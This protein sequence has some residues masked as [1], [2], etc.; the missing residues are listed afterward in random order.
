MAGNFDT[1]VSSTS[2]TFAGWSRTEKVKSIG[3]S[4][5]MKPIYMEEDVHTCSSLSLLFIHERF[6]TGIDPMHL[7]ATRYLYVIP[8]PIPPH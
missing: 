1:L 2:R 6:A 5:V 7:P 8:K 4:D 3:T